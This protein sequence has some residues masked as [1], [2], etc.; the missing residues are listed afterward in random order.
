MAKT[1]SHFDLERF[2]AA[3]SDKTRLRLLNLMQEGE[4]CVCFFV[5]VLGELQPK[6]S[7]HLAF[8]R[9]AGI[10]SARRDGKWMH[11][12][13]TFPED[14]HARQLLGCVLACLKD[15]TEMQRDRARLVKVCCMPSPPVQLLG[16]PKPASIST[17]G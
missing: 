11:Y 10:V 6:I 3:L 13:I 7:R 8:L 5:E 4:V 17:R 16:A 9:D 1:A 14:A 15:D 2:F 12:H